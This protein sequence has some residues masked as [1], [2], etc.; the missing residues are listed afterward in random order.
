MGLPTAILLVLAVTLRLTDPQ[1]PAMA[2]MSLPAAST[3]D[4]LSLANYLMR[5]PF[6]PKRPRL[7]CRL[8]PEAQMQGIFDA[9]SAAKRD[10]VRLD[11]I[12]RY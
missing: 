8:L 10:T 11:K 7:E 9:I 3:E 2:G 5:R 12:H 4:A 1:L 6:G